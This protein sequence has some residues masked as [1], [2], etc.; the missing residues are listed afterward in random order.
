MDLGE[1][2]SNSFEYAKKLLAGPASR[3]IIL[4]ILGVVP[5]INWIVMGYAAS[6]LRESPSTDAPPKLEK[7]GDMFVDG[8][9]IFFASLIYMLIPLIL[10]GAG[11]ASFVV[12]FVMRGGLDLD[13]S[14]GFVP[15]EML[16]FGGAA[17][18]LVLVGVVVGFFMLIVLAAGVA[19]MIKTG[20]FGKAFA[21][22]EIFDVIRRVGWGKYLVWVI[23]VAVIAVVIGGIARAIPYIAWLVQA[24]ISPVLGVFFF[25]SLGL[26]YNEGAPPDL[27]VPATAPAVSGVSCTSCGAAL[28][29]SQRFCA[30]CG[31]RAP[32]SPSIPAPPSPSAET[33]FCTSCGAR[34]PVR[35]NFCAN[36]GA[37]QP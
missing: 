7:Y 27:Q 19:H 9:K 31:A 10:I 15:G 1:N 22:G 4:I 28:Q 36:C 2:L 11:I 25:R 30:K 5:L 13:I 21:F 29:P 18:V 33:K 20:K 34:I 14:S 24:I 23:L 37:R 12:P 26:L 6:V 16:L 8:A 35:A 17:L 32:V 3:L